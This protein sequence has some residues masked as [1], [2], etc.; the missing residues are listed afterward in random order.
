M[1]AS[2]RRIAGSRDSPAC[3]RA[4]SVEMSDFDDS[5]PPPGGDPPADRPQPEAGETIEATGSVGQG[6]YV[7]QP[8]DCMSSIAKDH[9]YLWETLWNHPANAEL[10]AVRKDPNILL[11]G[12]RV[13]LP[14]REPKQEA[15]QTEMRH[16]FMRRGEP[17]SLVL[18]L[19]QDHKPRVNAPYVLTVDQSGANAVRQ[20]TFSGVTDAEGKIEVLIPNNARRGVLLVGA[21]PERDEYIIDL[22]RIDPIDTW[23]G[24]QTR[25]NNL[26]YACEQTGEFDEPTREALNAFRAAEGLERSEDIDEPTRAR[27]KER[28]GC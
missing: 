18:R 23:S 9:G 10:N 25:L 27:L 20:R 15:G 3:Q 16:R 19:Q 6:E 7:V 1:G 22:G 5:Q 2:G 26:G 14:P 21:A 12:D 13:T 28:H 17:C 4:L 11:P 8:G 24:V